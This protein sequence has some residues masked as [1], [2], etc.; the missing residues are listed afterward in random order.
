LNALFK[1]I[2][3]QLGKKF[4]FSEIPG[5]F[6][7]RDLTPS[8]ELLERANI[9]Y[10]VTR[11]AAQGIPLGAQIEGN[12]FK[13]ILLDVA[14]SQTLLGLNLGFW[15]TNPLE[16][17]INKGNIVEAFIGQEL[18]AYEDPIKQAELFYWTREKA[19]S[20]VEVD[21]VMQQRETIIP[22]EVK[23]G[24]GTTLKSMNM[25]LES[26]THAPYGIRF[27]T[28][29]YSIHQKIYSYPLFAVAYAIMQDK[30]AVHALL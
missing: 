27:S 1:G 8:F 9:V 24:K 21:F 20:E 30:R 25:F 16:Q 22:I 7:K 5:E 10:K 19:G 14:L 4:K 15:L 18:I 3:V 26:H 23:S 11:S 17:F 12:D 6:R 2:P 13:A 29:N 28:N